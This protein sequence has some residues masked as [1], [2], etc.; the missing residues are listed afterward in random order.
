MLL[1]LV[2]QKGSQVFLRGMICQLKKV[3]TL[4]ESFCAC[5]F[6]AM[7]D[8]CFGRLLS[9]NAEAGGDRDDLAASVGAVGLSRLSFVF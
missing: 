8:C 3:L 9:A 4:D 7:L 1:M 6:V 5:C 2:I